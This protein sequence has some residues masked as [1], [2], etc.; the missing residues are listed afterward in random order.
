MVF[1]RRFL[2]SMQL[3]CSFEAAARLESFTAAAAELSL[4]QSAISRQIRA[5]EDILG[6]DLFHRERQ[7]VR[8]TRAGEAYAREIRDALN[9]VSAATLGFRASPR[10]GSLNLAVL[11]TFGA[12]WLAPRLRGFADAFPEIT[13]NL[14]TRLA[15]FDF[16]LD[17]VDAAIHYGMEN[18]SGARM[19]PLLSE[20]VIPVCSPEFARRHPLG[21]I[22][23][24][25][26][27]PLLHLASRPD[28]WER[29]FTAMHCPVTDLRGMVCDEF[30]LTSQAAAAGMGVALLPRF[31]IE[32]ELQR[33]E[34]ILALDAPM[35]GGERYFLAWPA[36][37]RDYAPLRHFRE[38]LVQQAEQDALHHVVAEESERS[39]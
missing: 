11:P 24:V 16:A 30:T 32:R 37:R 27:V 25:L 14:T 33:G 19:V 10:G 9:M 39:F 34:L 18:W 5:L 8:L 26:N 17:H 31:L 7:T 36:E 12:R 28:A 23:D 21:R 20:V 13:V 22:E 38:W 2:P 15:P 3:L 4:T 6:S 35:S 29:W 1:V